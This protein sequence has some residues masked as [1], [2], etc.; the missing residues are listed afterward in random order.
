MEWEG[1][2][3]SGQFPYL[4]SID[5]ILGFIAHLEPQSYRILM[6]REYPEIAGL[7]QKYA[8][9]YEVLTPPKQWM[10]WTPYYRKMFRFF[11]LHSFEAVLCVGLKASFR[12]I[13]VK[14][15]FNSNLVWFLPNAF[16]NGQQ[17]WMFKHL[18]SLFSD[19]IMTNSESAINQ[20]GRDSYFKR[21]ILF[22]HNGFDLNLKP[23][24]L[25]E[26]FLKR[27]NLRLPLKKA[28]DEEEKKAA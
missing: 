21:K 12:S 2:S 1:L 22:I 9:T 4:R 13:F 10:E 11:R 17:N 16:E 20:L 26:F 5:Q 18:A 27:F 3:P 28:V 19:F 7:F 24:F 14:M 25:S 15:W 8:I 23:D 6:D